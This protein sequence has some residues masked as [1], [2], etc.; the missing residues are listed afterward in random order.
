MAGPPIPML[1]SSNRARGE[2]SLRRCGGQDR[3]SVRAAS[4]R[5]HR[6]RKLKVKLDTGFKVAGGASSSATVTVTFA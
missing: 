6:H 2:G 3:A 4:L 5:K 1:E